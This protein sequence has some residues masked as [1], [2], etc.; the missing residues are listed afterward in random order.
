MSELLPCPFCGGEAR[1]AVKSYGDTH[2]WRIYCDVIGCA[3]GS[4]GV[5]HSE[6]EAIAAWN[7]RASGSETANDRAVAAM[8][9]AA[10]NW[11]K[12]DAELRKALDFMRI[13][14]SEDAH[15]GE[16]AISREF[17]KAEGLRK[18]D[19]IEMS[20]KD[21]LILLDEFG[22]SE[23]TCRNIDDEFP[24]FQCSECEC[25]AVV[26]YGSSGDGLPNYCPNC[27]AKVVEQ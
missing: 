2:Y 24:Y 13:W 15:L 18:L 3:F 23:R 26:G 11:A 5:Y 4:S 8:N 1:T 17:E 19:A 14:I 7:T 25:N 22:L 9:K 21:A 12:A 10:G 6:A 27:G 16:S 20:Y